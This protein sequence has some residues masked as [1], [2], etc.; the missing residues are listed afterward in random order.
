MTNI[1]RLGLCVTCK[2]Y[3][4]YPPAE[5]TWNVSGNEEWRLMTGNTKADKLTELVNTS[6]TVFINCSGV[7]RSVSCSVGDSASDTFQVCEC[8][9]G[10]LR[11][12]GQIAF[13]DDVLGSVEVCGKSQHAL[14]SST[15][16]EY[17]WE[18][19]GDFLHPVSDRFRCLSHCLEFV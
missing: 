4:G 12:L 16:R 7:E 13:F 19:L 11:P 14:W 18:V 17:L 5:F 9:T 6:S 2:S 1:S 8:F 3:G 10:S 15:L